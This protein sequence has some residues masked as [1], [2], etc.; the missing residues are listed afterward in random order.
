MSQ[1]TSELPKISGVGDFFNVLAQA[2]LVDRQAERENVA[3]FNK[4]AYDALAT[5]DRTQ[6]TGFGVGGN[7]AAGKVQ[8]GFV[9][10]PAMLLVGVA[11][12]A[13]IYFAVK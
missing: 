12:I 5:S 6:L 7:A 3:A 2:Y 1:T 4:Y 13:A 10:T 9:L 8:T 11:A